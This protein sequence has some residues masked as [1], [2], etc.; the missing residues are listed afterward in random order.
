MTP[1]YRF[2]VLGRAVGKERPRVFRGHAVTPERTAAWESNVAWQLQDC[3]NNS[4]YEFEPYTGDIALTLVFFMAGRT[5]D[6][7]N[8]AK[9]VM[10]AA[11]GILYKDD[12]QV[13]TLCVERRK[14]RKDSEHV[15][16]SIRSL[17]P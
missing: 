16:I 7:D 1:E 5:P 14:S 13:A 9:A 12:R 6:V 2:T 15:V 11:N 4:P 17:T 8:L 3:I 10:D